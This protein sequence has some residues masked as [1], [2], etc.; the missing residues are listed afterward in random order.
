MTLDATKKKI[1]YFVLLLAAS[2]SIAAGVKNAL[3]YSQDFQWDAAKCLMLRINPY[4][5]SLSATAQTDHPALRDFFEY[6]ASIDAKQKVEAN[7]FPSLLFLLSVF[8]LMPYRTAVVVWLICNLFCTVAIVYLLRKTFM[9]QLPEEMYVVLSL[10]MIAG[11][12]WRNQI[13]VGQHTLFSLFFF[14]LAVYLSESGRWLPSSLALAVSYFKY[15]LTAP[16]ALYFIYK[17]R[18]REFAVS[19][20][21]HIAGTAFGAY[22]L[23]ASFIDMIKQPLAV[24][25]ALASEGSIDISALSGGASWSMLAALVIMALLFAAAVRLPAGFDNEFFSLLTLVSL[26]I[27]YHRSYDF[28]VAVI[29]F[30]GIYAMQGRLKWLE[31]RAFICCYAALLLYMFFMLRFLHESAGSLSALALLY[32]TFLLNYAI[33]FTRVVKGGGTNG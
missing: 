31:G 13:G 6:F 23:K 7:Q 30:T 10:L 21:I 32:Y 28:F 15:T 9:K 22:W 17:K 33:T 24:S 8:T 2:V 25:S 14:L 3:R 29:V 12:P 18:W 27:T 26:I 11:T 5:L 19:V 20:A 16:L 1:I 4:E